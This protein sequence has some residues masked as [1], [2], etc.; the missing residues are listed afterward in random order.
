MKRQVMR[1]ALPLSLFLVS[2]VPVIAQAPATPPATP[3]A[4]V[5]GQPPYQPPS[6]RFEATGMSL[7]DAIKLTLQHEPTIKLREA[8]VDFQQ[9]VL[10]SQKGLFDYL[11]RV[12]GTF[13]REQRELVDSV[14][15][16]E[17]ERRDDLRQAITEVTDLSQSLLAAGAILQDKNLAFNNP[18]GMNLS[19]I[20]DRNVLNQLQIL[21]AEL[22]LYRDVLASP[23]LTDQTVRD[24]IINLREVTIGRHIDT[25]NA[26]QAT[27]AGLPG[28]F[29]T[30]LDNLGPT[31]DEEW[32]KRGALVLDVDKLFRSGITVR[33]F[34]DL[35]YQSQN[36][37]GKDSD[38]P[39][40][41]GM[42]SAPL[43]EGEIGFDIVLPLLRGAG[44]TSVA[45]A[46]TASKHDLEASRLQL[47]FQHSQSVLATIQAYWQAR[48]AADQVE[49]LRR[50]V[51]I[52][53]ELAALTRALIAAQ[54]RPRAEEA[55]VLA[56]TADSRSRYEAAQRQ[57]NDAR[58]NLA[59]VM[60]VALADALAIPL[61]KDPYPQ[62]PAA[63]TIDPQAY[64]RFIKDAITKR[65]DRQAVGQ[66][67]SSGKALVDGARIDTRPLLNVN[68][69]GWGT[70]VQQGLGYDDWVFRS[71]RVGFTFEKPFGN[72]TAHGLLEARRAELHQTQIDSTD[73]DRVIAL[74]VVQ[75][76][77]SLKVAADRLRSAEE[78][79]RNYDQTMTNEQA[80][81]KAGDASLIDT[82]LTEQQTTGARLAYITAQQEYA[83]LLATLRHEAGMLVQD[84]RVDG[85]QLVSVP[86]ALV[87]K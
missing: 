22:V 29:Q 77:E 27:I 3:A 68:A 15:E 9:G 70:S 26:E 69:R 72:N 81:L 58:I 74:R 14:I 43:S 57:L 49:V 4:G 86:P 79:V 16:D 32:D 71:G 17:Q 44:R 82:I 83:S 53:G 59:Q 33:P 84:G 65:F 36:F 67:E 12:D 37:V 78:A 39:D 46:E 28:Q 35:R 13:G 31:P 41:G 52:Q 24:G 56:A 20:R 40:F 11:F 34:V 10:R 64:G 66:A 23:N 55:R 63:L 25:F 6:M 50:S 85:A 54:E 76:A 87:G 62:P 47:L 75:L 38:D 42:G 2:V 61:A 1:V 30:R 7:L 51:A 18:A 21:Q 80:R 19:T 48:A 73:L 8:D 60:G 45:A 5:A